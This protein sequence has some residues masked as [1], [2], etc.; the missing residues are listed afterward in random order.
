MKS[1]TSTT[2]GRHVKVVLAAAMFCASSLAFAQATVKIKHAAGE[3]TV[4]VNPKKVVVFDLASLDTMKVLG[5]K[6]T[7]VPA[8]K[9]PAG[10]AEY[11]AK[12]YPKVGTVF[13]PDYEAVFGMSPD[14]IIIGGRSGPKYAELSKIAP[15][16]DLT[17]DP[18]HLIDSVKRNTRILGDIY[19]KKDQ[20]NAAVSE[21]DASIKAL[22]AKAAKAGPGLIILTVGNKMSAYG[23][24][25]R[26]GV[27]HDEFGIKP[28][29]TT[30][31]TA[32]H[33]QS[34]SFEFIHKTDPQW[35]FVIDRDTAIG[36]AERS[37]QQALDNEL[38]KKT[39]AYK[40]NQIVY[41]DSANWYL[42]G[43]AGLT[44]L[45]SN[46]AQISKALDGKQ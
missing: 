40:K 22:Q 25:S 26:F 5:E 33:G 23:P 21:L 8:I 46:I 32:N 43:S 2:V 34:V 30:L 20:A 45:N 42:L 35:L 44:A 7:A 11:A 16:I 27:I 1:V 29:V 37:A 14:L 39:T 19:N 15:T 28:A 6:A 24:N 17:V 38:I 41:L 12:T 10:L 18:K 36:R 13:E 3:T 4:P 9:Y 31:E